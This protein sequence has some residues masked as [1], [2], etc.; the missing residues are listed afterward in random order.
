MYADVPALSVCATL[1]TAGQLCFYMPPPH[2]A[3]GNSGAGS[4]FGVFVHGHIS[5]LEVCVLQK[6]WTVRYQKA[7]GLIINFSP[8][9]MSPISF[10][11]GPFPKLLLRDHEKNM[12]RFLS[13]LSS[14]LS[15][16]SDLPD[17]CF[18]A[19]CWLKNKNKDSTCYAKLMRNVNDVLLQWKAPLV[20]SKSNSGTFFGVESVERS[21]LALCFEGAGLQGIW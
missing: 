10:F 16:L 1:I 5:A 21:E 18:L 19:S 13:A 20:R 7:T 6:L 4:D 11:F 12:P 8:R 15:S 14:R 9:L 17:L 2:V 3:H